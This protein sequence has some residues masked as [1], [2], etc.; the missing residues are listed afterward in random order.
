MNYYFA[1]DK[2]PEHRVTTVNSAG[3]TA[4]WTVRENNKFTITGIALTNNAAAQEVKFV[5]GS[6][7]GN[8]SMDVA[9]FNPAA[10]GFIS[11]VLGPLDGSAANYN[12]YVIGDGTG[13]TNGQHIVL[14]GFETPIDG[15][16]FKR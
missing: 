9:K 3:T 10:S 5:A 2:T 4:V 12:L 16:S 8:P 6:T 7:N 15:V 11:P 14:T 1:T 13:G